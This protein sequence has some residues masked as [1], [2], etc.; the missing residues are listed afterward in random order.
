[1][2]EY[3]IWEDE[4]QN[5][6]SGM[7]IPANKIYKVADFYELSCMS[8]NGVSVAEIDSLNESFN[9]F[10]NI[11]ETINDVTVME[12][13]LTEQGFKFDSVSWLPDLPVIQNLVYFDTYNQEFDDLAMCDEINAY[14]WWNGNNHKTETTGGDITVTDVTVEDHIHLDLDVYDGN[15]NY[16]TNG[17]RFYHEKVYKILELDGEVVTDTFLLIES[18]QYES[19]HDTARVLTNDELD[20]H[21][22]EIGYE[23]ESE[24]EE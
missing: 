9:T 22:K 19:S 20:K 14:D 11:G 3:Q 6:E 24:D 13:F 5:H 12:Q 1:M 23:I 21:L 17:I 2:K 8:I 10:K 15:G 16:Y 7:L 4:N 18:S